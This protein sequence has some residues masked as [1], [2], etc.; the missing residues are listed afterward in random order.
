[1]TCLSSP[2]PE[3]KI[4]PTR[5][6]VLLVDD[7]PESIDLVKVYLQ[8][9]EIDLTVTTDGN[10][11][12]EAFKRAAYDLVLMDIEMPELDGC[13]ATRAIRYWEIEN[14]RTPT[15]ITALTG[16]RSTEEV[17]RI[18]ASGCSNYL[19][20]PISKVVLLQCLSQFLRANRTKP[21]HHGNGVGHRDG[22]RS[23]DYSW[24]EHTK[25]HG[26]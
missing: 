26:A 2:T 5:H 16:V 10:H 18:F 12:L 17:G 15:P 23:K 21:A 25:S 24:L 14:S 19:T 8:G 9:S 13:A 4:L 7:S 11:G 20:K 22:L 3:N 6:R 1:M